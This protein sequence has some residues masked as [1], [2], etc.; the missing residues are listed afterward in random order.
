[1]TMEELRAILVECAGPTEELAGDLADA[2]FAALG[3]DS[4]AVIETAARIRQRL[5]VV[6]PDA[7]VADLRSPAELLAAV[8][9]ARAAG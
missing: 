6:V 5:G 7:V 9:A 1:M 2:E 8:N 3:V 4:L